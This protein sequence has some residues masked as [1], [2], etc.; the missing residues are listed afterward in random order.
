MRHLL[1]GA[2]LVL[3]GCCSYPGKAYVEADE[4]T[5]EWSRPKLEEWAEAKGG[6]WPEAVRLKM[7]SVD[8]RIQQ[9]KTKGQE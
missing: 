7:D 5:Y 6:A 1:L 8:A 9:A 3:A 2:V 4:S